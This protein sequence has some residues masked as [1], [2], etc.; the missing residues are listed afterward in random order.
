MRIKLSVRSDQCAADLACRIQLR[1]HLLSNHV[2]SVPDNMAKPTNLT[3]ALRCP[4][5]GTQYEQQGLLEPR[6]TH[7]GHTLSTSA[8]QPVRTTPHVVHAWSSKAHIANT[9]CV[10]A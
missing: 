1:H 5:L 2:G 6:V 7:C 4:I 8:L 3:D 10:C 9:S